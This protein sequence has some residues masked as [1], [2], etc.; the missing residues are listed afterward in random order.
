MCSAH[1]FIDIILIWMHVRVCKNLSIPVGEYL[2][3]QQ[4]VVSIGFNIQQYWVHRSFVR[5]VLGRLILHL[6]GIGLR[7][8][9]LGLQFS[10]HL[11]AEENSARIVHMT[12]E[13]AALVCF[14][15]PV[16]SKICKDVCNRMWM[17]VTANQTGVEQFQ[18]CWFSAYYKAILLPYRFVA[19][20][21]MS[22]GISCHWLLQKNRLSSAWRQT[23]EA[24]WW[25]GKLKWFK[26]GLLMAGTPWVPE[27]A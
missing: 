5:L 7:A 25:T 12:Y 23:T 20:I 18:N 8:M 13:K 11:A 2:I 9:V 1:T 27:I 15:L 21:S 24:T 10:F 16:I 22:R 4:S 6:F 3:V 19:H 17:S 14:C 26:R